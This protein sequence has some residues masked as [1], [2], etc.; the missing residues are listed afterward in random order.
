MGPDCFASG[1]GQTR[2]ELVGLIS[3]NPHTGSKARP[4]TVSACEARRTLIEQR[5]TLGLSVQR[6]HQDLM[7]EYEFLGSC[8]AAAVFRRLSW[9]R[10][11]SNGRAP[12]GPIPRRLTSG[13]LAPR[14]PKCAVASWTE[15]LANIS[16]TFARFCFVDD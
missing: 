6:I 1:I 2:A 11:K 8:S 10:R 3:V 13:V 7:S 15:P 5:V 14:R 9:V 12:S 16:V 4:G